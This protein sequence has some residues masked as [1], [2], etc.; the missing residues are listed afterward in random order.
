MR[1]VGSRGSLSCRTEGETSKRQV[2][3]IWPAG[4]ASD[5]G[6]NLMSCP[7]PYFPSR[8]RFCLQSWWETVV[9]AD[10]ALLAHGSSQL[11]MNGV[12]VGLEKVCGWSL[13]AALR[14]AWRMGRH[15]GCALVPVSRAPCGRGRFSP[16][17]CRARL[18]PV[19]CRPIA[20]SWDIPSEGAIRQR[21][22]DRDTQWHDENA[23][24]AAPKSC[25]PRTRGGH[26]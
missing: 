7:I 1:H 4:V 22:R 6:E 2:L 20:A 12:S 8:F 15:A 10:V 13:R 17:L 21:Q 25:L 19:L 23:G 24:R 14:D 11:R 5:D 26:R 9:H 3:Q 16:C 18:Q